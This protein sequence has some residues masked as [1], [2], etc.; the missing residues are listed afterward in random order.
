MATGTGLKST[1][2][3]LS[4]IMDL[5]YGIDNV[6]VVF[7]IKKGVMP[8]SILYIQK[9]AIGS[10]YLFNR[11]RQTHMWVDLAL[12]VFQ[13]TH[14]IECNIPKIPHHI[15]RPISTHDSVY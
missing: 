15:T 5:F 7:F 10:F 4:Y 6:S 9:R 8:Y 12:S 14:S 1:I 2:F 3:A 11:V 13:F